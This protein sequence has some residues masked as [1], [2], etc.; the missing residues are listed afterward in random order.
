MGAARHQVVARALR[1]RLGQH[2]RLDVDEPRLVQIVAHR[3]RDAM[4]QQQPLA[5]LLAAQVDV[6]EA[7][8]HFLAHVLIELE[9]QRLG[10]VQNLELLAQQLRPGRTSDWRSP[11]RAAG[12]APAP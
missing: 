4:T 2:R 8:P 1:R 7:Q 12:F 11:S 3:A 6:A 9:R 5:H 10:A